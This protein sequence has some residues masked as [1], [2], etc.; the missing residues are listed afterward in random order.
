MAQAVDFADD[1]SVAWAEPNVVVRA[2]WVLTNDP[3]FLTSGAWGQSYDDL[4]GLKKIRVEQGLGRDPRR[5]ARRT[6]DRRRGRR[7]GP[8]LG[9]RGHSRQRGRSLGEITGNQLDDDH[10]GFVDDIARLGLRDL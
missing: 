6:A 10:N 9:A 3:Y 5:I 1:P 2:Q 8:R 7:L 4:W